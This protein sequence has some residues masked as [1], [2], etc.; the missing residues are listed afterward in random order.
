MRSLPLFAGQESSE[1][2]SPRLLLVSD[3]DGTLIAPAP[4]RPDVVEALDRFRRLVDEGTGI[5]LAYATGRDYDLALEGMRAF[6]L[7]TPDVILS[8][9]GTRILHRIRDTGTFEEDPSY[10]ARLESA[11]APCERARIDMRVRLLDGVE[12]QEEIKQGPFKISFYVDPDVDDDVVLSRLSG[13]LDDDC[14]RVKVVFSRDP[15]DLRGLVDILPREVSKASATRYL[16]DRL[17]LAPASVLYFGDSGNDTDALLA[18]FNAVLVGNAPESLRSFLR[19]RANRA[20]IGDRLYFARSPY[21]AG[22]IEGCRHFEV[23]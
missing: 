14:D 8:D 18:G 13:C 7:P 11:L 16:S 15:V 2:S 12:P 1:E 5:V 23:L 17:G 22:V 20:G 21:A 10:A 3:L 19:V 9:V 4:V 6:D